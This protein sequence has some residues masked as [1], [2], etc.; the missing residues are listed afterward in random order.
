MYTDK[1]FE[2]YK[3]RLIYEGGERQDIRYNG[4]QYLCSF[5]GIDPDEMAAALL[6]EGR[7]VLFDDSSISAAQR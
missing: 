1:T 3:N 5:P 7:D 6:Q 4:I 2:C